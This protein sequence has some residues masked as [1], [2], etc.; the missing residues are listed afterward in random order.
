MIGTGRAFSIGTLCLLWVTAVLSR[1]DNETREKQQARWGILSGYS[2]THV[3]VGSTQEK[4]SA[5]DFVFRRRSVLKTTGKG[6][7]RGSHDLLLEIPVSLLLE[8]DGRP[9]IIAL[10]L[11]AC[12][13]WHCRPT[14]YPYIFAGGGPV[15][16]AADIPGMSTRWNGNYQAGCGVKFNP[17]SACS[18]IIEYR[19]HH[20]SNGGRSEPNDALNSSKVL[21]GMEWRF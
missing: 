8:P 17:E 5:W 15:Y 7:Y 11:L 2:T 3:G 4:V 19:F 16:K 13:T 1:A 12:W 14:G 18:W 6:W 9:P 20:I 21:A 10:N